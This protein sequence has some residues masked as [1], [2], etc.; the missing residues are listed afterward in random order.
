MALAYLPVT[1][2]LG[3]YRGLVLRYKPVNHQICWITGAYVA[4]AAINS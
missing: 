2:L 1:R 4:L 3:D